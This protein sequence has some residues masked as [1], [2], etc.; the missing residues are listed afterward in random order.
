MGL[1]PVLIG[2]RTLVRTMAHPFRVGVDEGVDCQETC[3]ELVW[4]EE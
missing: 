3:S 1:L 4:M 2:P